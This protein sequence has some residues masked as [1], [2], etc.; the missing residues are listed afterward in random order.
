MELMYVVMF[1]NINI[2]NLLICLI[3]RQ[4]LVDNY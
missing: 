4:R 3:L 1:V 2:G